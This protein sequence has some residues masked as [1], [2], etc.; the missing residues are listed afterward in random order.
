MIR[1]ENDYT[2]LERTIKLSRL[3]TLAHGSTILEHPTALN[4]KTNLIYRGCDHG[5]TLSLPL[6][7]HYAEVFVTRPMMDT[8]Y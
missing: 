2:T 1:L 6:Y 7:C 8:A 5:F 3:E 4:M